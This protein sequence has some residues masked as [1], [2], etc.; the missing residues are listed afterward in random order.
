MNKKDIKTYNEIMKNMHTTSEV[1]QNSF[2]DVLNQS[3]K[4]PVLIENRRQRSCFSGPKIRRLFNWS[5]N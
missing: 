1:I 4:G 5:A 2:K 3:E